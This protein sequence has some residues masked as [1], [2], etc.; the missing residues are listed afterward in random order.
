[1]TSLKKIV[2]SPQE[3]ENII[4]NAVK[5]AL[6]NAT[7]G[8]AAVADDSVVGDSVAGASVDADSAAGGSVDADSVG[9]G[10]AAVGSVDVKIFDWKILLEEK[11][12]RLTMKVNPRRKSLCLKCPHIQNLMM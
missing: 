5:T 2:L 3:L 12:E 7:I 4:S 11:E 8:S 10:S 1:M 6:S 9:G